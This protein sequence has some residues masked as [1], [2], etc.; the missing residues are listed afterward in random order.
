[1]KSYRQREQGVTMITLVI[2]LGIGGFLLLL[3]F[4]VGPLYME[5]SKIMNAMAAVEKTVD[6]EQETKRFVSKAIIKRM[7]VNGVV[8]V[9]AEDFKITKEGNHYLKVE[10][11]YEAIAP[12]FGNLS[13]LA[14]FHEEFEVGE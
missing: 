10:L 2:M 8:A 7:D 5:H 11:D 3:L 4:K 13:A 14:E 12:I 1:M 9:A 6:I